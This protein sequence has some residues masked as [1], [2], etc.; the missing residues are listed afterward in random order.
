MQQA[1]QHGEQLYLE[2]LHVGQSI[3]LSNQS[4]TV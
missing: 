1:H 2:D 4:R 3:S